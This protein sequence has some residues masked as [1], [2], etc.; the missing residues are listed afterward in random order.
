[1]DAYAIALCKIVNCFAC[2]GCTETVDC[3]GCTT[4]SF[5]SARFKRQEMLECKTH[6]VGCARDAMCEFTLF[7]ET[8]P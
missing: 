8:A 4:A 2:K 7:G 6:F 3:H 5:P 1:M